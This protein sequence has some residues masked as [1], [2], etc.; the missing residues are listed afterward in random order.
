M[1][2]EWN[3]HITYTCVPQQIGVNNNS[4]N[5]DCVHEQKCLC[6]KVHEMCMYWRWKTTPISDQKSHGLEKILQHSPP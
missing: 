3:E 1:Q 5:T 4:A 6:S 2:V